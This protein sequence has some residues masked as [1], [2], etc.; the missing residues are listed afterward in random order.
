MGSDYQPPVVDP[1]AITDRAHKMQA[2]ACV[3]LLFSRACAAAAAAASHPPHAPK[4]Q[5]KVLD[6]DARI[7]LIKGFLTDEEADHIRTISGERM[8]RSGVVEADGGTAISDIR[9]SS[10]TF[11]ER[12][13]DE[14]V[15]RVEERIAAWTLLPVHNGEGLQVRVCVR[16]RVRVRARQRL[17]RL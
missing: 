3:C 1:A 14:V 7:F 17:R 13:E 8:T 15:K 6:A 5:P 10:G 11:L 2:R 9:T 12:G 16:G 4:Q